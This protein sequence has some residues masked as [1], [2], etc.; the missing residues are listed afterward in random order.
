MKKGIG[1]FSGKLVAIHSKTS[2]GR[3]F[4]LP[5]NRGRLRR[6]TRASA[7]TCERS[8]HAVD[9]NV[10]VRLITRDDEKQVGIAETFIGRGVWASHVVLAETM[11]VLDDVYG[12][13]HTEIATAI[14]MLLN[15]RSLTLEDRE[16]VE[17]ALEH[18]R[19][20]PS[21]GFSDCL[22]LEIARKAGHLPLGTFDRN[23]SKLDGAER[24]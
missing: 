3:F 23:L 5:R 17:I 7:G 12:L 16:I 8:M 20:K 21:L 19:R 15:N 13:D 10:L 9:T 11:W 4:R 18:Y 6:W 24:L 1:W 14:D 22:I 2:T